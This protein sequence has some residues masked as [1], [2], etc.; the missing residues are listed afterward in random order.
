[1]ESRTLPEALLLVVGTLVLELSSSEWEL[2]RRY[3]LASGSHR[4]RLRILWSS[5]QMML[6]LGLCP[7][8]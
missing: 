2:L 6:K 4:C 5:W 7:G 3:T 1:M 8:S